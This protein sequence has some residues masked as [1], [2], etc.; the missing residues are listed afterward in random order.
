MSSK[1]HPKPNPSQ[2]AAAQQTW[3]SK[4][5]NHLRK[6]ILD[7][8]NKELEYRTRLNRNGVLTPE[9]IS[10]QGIKCLTTVLIEAL[11]LVDDQVLE[12]VPTPVPDLA[13]ERCQVHNNLE[14]TGQTHQVSL[15]IALSPVCVDKSMLLSQETPQGRREL[16]VDA[17][18]N[19]VTALLEEEEE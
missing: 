5:I 7:A 1:S 16:I 4:A 19:A 12:Q 3:R 18:A 17:L 11:G 8:H 9:M 10:R 2:I 15:V 6:S 13:Q 14:S